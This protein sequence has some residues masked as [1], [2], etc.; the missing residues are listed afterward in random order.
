MVVAFA[1]V[2]GL[3][4]TQRVSDRAG[5]VML[6]F[7]LLAGPASIAWWLLRGSVSPY[8]VLQFGGMG[9]AALCLLTAPRG[10]GPNW[11]FL[12]V[13]YALAKVAEGLDAQ[14]F[15]ASDELVSGHSLK[16]LLAALPALAVIPPLLALRAR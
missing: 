14:I 4:V 5:A 15:Q 8:A 11:V 6:C 7:G 1:G 10:P 3:V 9:T 12:L 13:A 16:H 2:L